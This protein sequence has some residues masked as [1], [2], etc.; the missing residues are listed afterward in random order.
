MQLS[1]IQY[2]WCDAR[3]AVRFWR[4]R[5]RRRLLRQPLV[6][7]WSPVWQI[8][9][10]YRFYHGNCDGDGDGGAGCNPPPSDVYILSYGCIFGWT[11]NCC[12]QWKKT[13]TNIW[14][15]ELFNLPALSLWSTMLLQIGRSRT[16][17]IDGDKSKK[18]HCFTIYIPLEPHYHSLLR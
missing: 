6:R 10:G 17:R 2:L 12:Q 7:S 1:T 13:K 11:T 9:S 3:Q 8:R 4:Q 18:T 16:W 15:F 14:T 5:N